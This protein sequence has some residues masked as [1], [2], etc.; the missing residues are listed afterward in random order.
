MTRFKTALCSGLFFLAL[1]AAASAETYQPVYSPSAT[2][3]MNVT[4]ERTDNG[5]MTHFKVMLTVPPLA[6]AIAQYNKIF[7]YTLMRTNDTLFSLRPALC[8]SGT[9]CNYGFPVQTGP[10]KPGD[11]VTVETDLPRA[12]VEAPGVSLHIGVGAEESGYY[13]TQNLIKSAP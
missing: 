5:P 8:P 9:R 4:V 10:F 7:P 6:P 1:G 13:P 11:R 3:N 2:P 12:F